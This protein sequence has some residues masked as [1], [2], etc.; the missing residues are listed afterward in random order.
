MNGIGKTLKMTEIKRLIMDGIQGVIIQNY[1]MENFRAGLI[2]TKT[3]EYLDLSM[4]LMDNL[5]IAMEGL[6]DN[7]SLKHLNLTSCKLPPHAITY[8]S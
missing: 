2:A 6:K 3:L 7:K 5:H 1:V 8:I 4:T